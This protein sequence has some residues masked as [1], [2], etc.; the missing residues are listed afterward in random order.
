M[1]KL[2]F[3]YDFGVYG[4]S[5][6]YGYG[7]RDVSWF[8]KLY[9]RNNSIKLAHNGEKIADILH[10]IKNDNNS[11]QTL[12]LAVGINDLLQTT[13]FA[14]KQSFYDLLS[15][16][17]EI[18]KIALTK[19][20]NVVVQSVLPVREELFPNQDWLDADMW[21]HNETI[22]RFNSELALLCQKLGVK[23]VDFY[24][25]FA[26]QNLAELYCDAVHLNDKGQ[27]FLKELYEKI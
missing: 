13:P 26:R 15:Q 8:D 4:D 5:I 24:K 6:A 7:N 11:Y 27:I 10:K 25:A 21:A 1:R 16:Y 19:A 18:L 9:G 23:F 17:E 14:E 12:I 3:T 22:K 20:E 2:V